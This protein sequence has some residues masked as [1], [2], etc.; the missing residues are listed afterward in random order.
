MTEMLKQA[1]MRVVGSKQ[2]LRAYTVDLREIYCQELPC[3]DN[4]VTASLA[5]NSVCSVA[6]ELE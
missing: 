4:V 6:I 1:D 3:T 5:A 2:V